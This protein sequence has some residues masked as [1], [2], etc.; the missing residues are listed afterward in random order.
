MI[1]TDAH[2]HLQDPRLGADRE[3]LIVECRD[4]GV[5]AMAVNGS[6]PEDWPDVS[7]LA[8]RHPGWVFPSFGVHPWYVDEAG[9]DWERRLRVLLGEHPGAGV[10]EVGLDRWML[11]NPDRWRALRDLPADVLPPGR[12]RQREFLEIQLGIAA[13]L[14]RPASLHCLEAWGDLLEVLRRGPVPAAGF[15]LHSYGGSAELIRP[16]ADLGAY[17][18]FPGYFLH[19]R[20]A[21]Q[22][23]VFRQVPPDRLLVETDAPDQRLPE[24]LET[25]PLSAPGSGSPVNHPANLA[26]VY[27]G[28]AR[29][30]GEPVDRLAERVAANF[31]RLFRSEPAAIRT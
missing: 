14:D 18:G 7:A 20:K 13:G 19:E 25:H 30:L 5:A 29:S 10:G 6:V 28:L 16:L 22:R 4:A 23:E 1:L 26:A 21:R 3:R 12:D 2:N 15:L 17:F 8:C 27:L 24:A 11:A 9:P 31:R